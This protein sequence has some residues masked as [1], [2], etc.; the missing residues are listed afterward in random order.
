MQ[1]HTESALA[2]ARFLETHPAVARVHHPGL[3]SSPWQAQAQ[4][5]LPRGA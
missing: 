2:V 1:R 4:T 3:D 5:Y